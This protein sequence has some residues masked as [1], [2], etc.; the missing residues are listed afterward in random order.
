[1]TSVLKSPDGLGPSRRPSSGASVLEPIPDHAMLDSTPSSRSMSPATRYGSPRQ[2]DD[3]PFFTVARYRNPTAPTTIELAAPEIPDSL[4]DLL[5]SPP[6]GGGETYYNGALDLSPLSPVELAFGKA[7]EAG[8]GEWL[9]K[10]ITQSPRTP[11]DEPH[12]SIA[13]SLSPTRSP[14][15]RGS[16]GNQE[17]VF[18][19]PDSENLPPGVTRRNN[20][21]TVVRGSVNFTIEFPSNTKP[22][23]MPK[24]KEKLARRISAP[25]TDHRPPETAN[26]LAEVKHR[27]SV[28]SELNKLSEQEEYEEDSGNRF[29]G[30]HLRPTKTKQNEDKLRSKEEKRAVLYQDASVTDAAERIENK[31]TGRNARS[32]SRSR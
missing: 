6:G 11:K 27:R 22:K 31:Q 30:M 24:P 3:V 19:P 21:E 16:D 14:R 15:E 25:P 9:G 8:T 2:A 12:L 18:Q 28:G 10:S 26:R 23:P 29:Y 32:K 7:P 17:H 20:E 13:K 5:T 4:P 1:M